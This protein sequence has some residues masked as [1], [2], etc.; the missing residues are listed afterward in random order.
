MEASYRSK[1]RASVFKHFGEEGNLHLPED[2]FFDEIKG[3]TAAQPPAAR[4]RN[5]GVGMCIDVD[6]SGTTWKFADTGEY[7]SVYRI[8]PTADDIRF[9]DSD[10]DVTVMTADTMAEA[11]RIT[12]VLMLSLN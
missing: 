11:V 5:R 8:K 12:K 6:M 4:F 9:L 10:L 2:W 1:L 3:P 7:E